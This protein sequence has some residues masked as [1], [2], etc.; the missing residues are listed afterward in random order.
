MVNARTSVRKH[1]TQNFCAVFNEACGARA[2][3]ENVILKTIFTAIV[4]E[5]NHVM[6]NVNI[7]GICSSSPKRITNVILVGIYPYCFAFWDVI[8]MKRYKVF[9]ICIQKKIAIEFLRFLIIFNISKLD[10]E[11]SFIERARSKFRTRF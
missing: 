2:Q 11:H 10:Y 5:W 9:K 7:I 4:Y 3:F 8:A 1:E 6:F